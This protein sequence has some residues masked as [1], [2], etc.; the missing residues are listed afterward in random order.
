MRRLKRDPY[1]V[2]AILLAVVA[3]WLILTDDKSGAQGPPVIGQPPSMDLAVAK[4]L[5]PPVTI[6]ITVVDHIPPNVIAP[7]DGDC[8]SWQPILEKYGIPYDKKT[9]AVMWRESQCSFHHNYN[10]TTRDDSWG[11]L[12]VNIYGSLAEKYAAVGFPREYVSTVEG[13]VALA[14]FLYS[15]CGWGPWTKP[16]TCPGGWPI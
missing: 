5:D 6:S 11:P 4:R 10:P 14:G 7:V 3:F 2:L 12:Q 1:L 9:K 13:S 8:A 16:Y 15:H